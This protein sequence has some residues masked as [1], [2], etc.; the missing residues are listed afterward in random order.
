VWLASL[1][2][3]L[4]VVPAEPSTDTNHALPNVA[5][6]ELLCL[7]FETYRAMVPSA[8]IVTSVWFM[9]TGENGT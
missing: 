8:Q 5:R 2:S 6:G 3:L 1:L 7:A 9:A 4:G